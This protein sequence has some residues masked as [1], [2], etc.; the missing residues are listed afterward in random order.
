MFSAISTTFNQ[1]WLFNQSGMIVLV[2]F[3]LAMF[4]IVG[5]SYILAKRA[6]KRE[7]VDAFA[8]QTGQA[9]A[10]GGSMI[11]LGLLLLGMAY[12]GYSSAPNIVVGAMSVVLGQSILV[13][14]FVLRASRSKEEVDASSI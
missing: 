12:Y 9:I 3:T 11:A 7:L 14:H 1:I 6:V 4:L 2:G 5:L 13:R 8:E 10:V